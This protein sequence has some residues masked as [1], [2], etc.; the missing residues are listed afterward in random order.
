MIDGR[1][2]RCSPEEE[3]VSSADIAEFFRDLEAR[4]FDLHSAQIVRRGRLLLA[5]AAAPF[6]LDSPHRGYSATKGIIAAAVLFAMQEGKLGFDDKVA[7]FFEA[8]LPA[9]LDERYRRLSLYHMLT[10][11]V[12]QASD[13]AFLRIIFEDPDGDLIRG[14]F[15]TPMSDEPGTRFF[16]NNAVPQ[17]LCFIVE[18][19]TGI[20]FEDY[21]QSR[22]CSSLGAEVVVQYSNGGHY[23]PS[24]SVLSSDAF[25]RF[26][27]FFLQEGAWEGRQLLD[28]E[29]VRS[30]GAFHVPTLAPQPG[31]G[32]GKG[33][34][35][36]LWRNAYGGYRFDGG[37]GQYAIVLPDEELAAV[38]MSNEL[39]SAVLLDVF[40]DR[41]VSRMRRRPLPASEAG[42][43]ALEAALGRFTLAPLGL[44]ADGS[45]RAS[46]QGKSFSFEGNELGIESLRFEG[47]E[48]GVARLSARVGGKDQSL[49]C[50]LGG[51]WAPNEAPFIYAPEMSH[52]NAIYTMDPN[53][54]LASGGWEGG[55]VFSFKLR[56]LAWLGE[57]LVRCDFSGG[58]LSLSL[59][60]R[61]SIGKAS[62]EGALRL[63][64]SRAG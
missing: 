50:G 2:P 58:G 52:S 25:L 64:A 5:A 38:F 40:Y 56:S 9:G 44:S 3:G 33:Y 37:R 16:Y 36:Q 24:T 47:A 59:P 23:E 57:Y 17:M 18:R 27:L 29:L 51:E 21:L 19:A 61:V 46:I 31:Y 43:A 11:Q 1:L 8:E 35:L 60:R 34:G 7:S 63:D 48:G 20:R 54:V 10:M 22:L 49:R 45:A 14:F 32:N 30:A 55:S 15:E 26:A 28:A 62:L 41:V 53:R 39:E 6:T 4:R 42:S 13:E 12:G